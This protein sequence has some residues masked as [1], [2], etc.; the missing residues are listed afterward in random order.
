VLKPGGAYWIHTPHP[1]ESPTAYERFGADGEAATDIHLHVWTYRDLYLQLRRS[2]FHRVRHVW[3]FPARRLGRVPVVSIRPVRY[4]EPL[5]ARLPRNERL[6]AI[7]GVDSCSVLAHRA[8]E[9]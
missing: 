6:V 3:W 4:I 9:P 8:I 5:A 1:L 2:G 7:A